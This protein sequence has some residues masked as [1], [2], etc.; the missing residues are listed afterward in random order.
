M[1]GQTTN[2]RLISTHARLCMPYLA[3]QLRVQS[4]ELRVL[5]DQEL[6]GTALP[7]GKGRSSI[8]GRAIEAVKFYKSVNYPPQ[9]LFKH[10]ITSREPSALEFVKDL[11]CTH[12]EDKSKVSTKLVWRCVSKSGRIL[13]LIRLRY[14]SR[15]EENYQNSRHSRRRI[16]EEDQGHMTELYRERGVV[17]RICESQHKCCQ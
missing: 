13:V 1:S 11:I 14:I 5:T 4:G 8:I 10:A 3:N 7:A 17:D 9:N 16:F 15:V 12:I 2:K 6:E